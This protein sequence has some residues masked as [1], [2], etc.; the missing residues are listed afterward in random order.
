M[1]R[2]E[3]SGLVLKDV[4][5]VQVTPEPPVGEVVA[6]PLVSES[7]SSSSLGPAVVN[8]LSGVDALDEVPS[9]KVIECKGH[10]LFLSCENEKRIR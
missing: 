7:I 10:Y 1:W 8:A 3:P 4:R 6:L 9:T 2:A 5:F